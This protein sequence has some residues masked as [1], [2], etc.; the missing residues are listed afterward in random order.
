VGEIALVR[1]VPRTA[2]VTALTGVEAYEIDASTF[3]AALAG[4]AGRA[5]AESVAAER[6]ANAPSAG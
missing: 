3:L 6:L 1:K 4:P 2:T 5:A